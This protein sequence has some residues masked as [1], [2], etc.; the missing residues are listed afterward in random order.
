MLQLLDR[1]SPADHL[2][3]VAFD[4]QLRRLPRPFLNALWEA[5]D[6]LEWHR[7]MIGGQSGS[8]GSRSSASQPMT[9]PGSSFT[10]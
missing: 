7:S 9:M 5:L 4:A 1:L 3:L 8:T 10:R 2:Q 6:A